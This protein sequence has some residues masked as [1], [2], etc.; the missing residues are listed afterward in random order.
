[1]TR[2]T[3][4]DHDGVSISPSALDTYQGCGERYRRRYIEN[5]W[6]R[7]HG[8]NLLIGKGVHAGAELDNRHKI[9]AGEPLSKSDTVEAAVAGYESAASEPDTEIVDDSQKPATQKKLNQAKDT[10]AKVAEVYADECSPE[11]PQPQF[12][13]E[14][15]A[16]LLATADG[17]RTFMVK[18]IIDV[19]SPTQ[20]IDLKTSGRK[21]SIDKVAESIAHTA[22]GWGVETLTRTNPNEPG[23]F[24]DEFIVEN[25]THYK[26]KPPERQRLVTQRSEGDYYAT[27]RRMAEVVHAIE[28]G[29]FPPAAKGSWQ[30]SAKWCEYFHDCEYVGPERKKVVA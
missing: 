26:T 1:M 11:I 14:P 21:W 8:L 27:W 25:L 24:P 13:E 19:A 12:V 4:P 5:E 10:T 23:R 20:V 6:R 7:I 9:A 2:I 3:W 16:I 29:V 28:S 22:Y 17:E 18:G 30:C 15:F